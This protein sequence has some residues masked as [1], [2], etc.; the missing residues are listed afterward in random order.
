VEKERSTILLEAV[1]DFER[2]RQMNEELRL[3]TIQNLKD[4]GTSTDEL[5][6]LR[7]YLR[8]EEQSRG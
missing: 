2:I 4:S 3:K 6:G 1:P 7:D 5:I 8:R